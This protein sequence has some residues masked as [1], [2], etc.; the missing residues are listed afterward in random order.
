MNGQELKLN[1]GGGNEKCSRI[2]CVGLN[3]RINVD[4]N[5]DL[6]QVHYPFEETVVE[7]GYI[8]DYTVNLHSHIQ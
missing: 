2:A 1:L 8:D 7:Q 6:N 4:I 5:D 3:T